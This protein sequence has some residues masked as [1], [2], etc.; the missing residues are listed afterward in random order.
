MKTI[1]NISENHTNSNGHTV[2]GICL[3]S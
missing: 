3:Y 2:T 1:N